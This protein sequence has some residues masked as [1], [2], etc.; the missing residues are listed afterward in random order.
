MPS[1]QWPKRFS[2]VESGGTIASRLALISAA[3]LTE[4]SRGLACLRYGAFP[5]SKVARSLSPI[6]EYLSLS[7]SPN[8]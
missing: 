3:S 5:K 1:Q 6:A 4:R 7:V 8:R 2:C